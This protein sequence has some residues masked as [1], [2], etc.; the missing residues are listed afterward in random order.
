MFVQQDPL[1]LARTAIQLGRFREAFDE[2]DAITTPIRQTPEWGLLT[3]M[4]NWRLGSF[5]QSH[6]TAKL[7]RDQYKSLGDVDGEMRAENVSA[8]GAFAVGDLDAA[9]QG[10]TKAR[11]LATRLGDDLMAARCANNLGNVWHYRDNNARA[12]TFYSV[13]VSGFESVAFAK[14]QGEAWHNTATVFRFMRQLP[15]SRNAADRAI[16]IAYEIGD[17]R[18]L[19]Q[20]MSGRGETVALQRDYRLA[21]DQVERALDLAIENEDKLTEIDALRVL[22]LVEQNDG[23]VEKAEQLALKAKDGAAEVDHPWMLAVVQRRLGDLYR[24]T[25]R[26]TDAAVAYEEAAAHYDRLGSKSNAEEMRKLS[27]ELAGS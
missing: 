4:T 14:G 26:S 27:S 12:L 2:L 24:D 17:R 21:R 25:N 1:R 23:S 11:A 10:F 3:S 13:A 6:A 8:A 15:A 16:D 22:S 5:A 9:A 19:A 20:A 18:L 7:A